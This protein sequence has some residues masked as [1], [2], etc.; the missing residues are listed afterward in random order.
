MWKVVRIVLTLSFTGI[1]WY[2][3]EIPGSSKEW[4]DIFLR[5]H[6]YPVFCFALAGDLLTQV[7]SYL[8]KTYKTGSITK[9]WVKKLLEHI[10][11]ERLGGRNYQTRISLLR[12]QKGYKLWWFYLVKMPVYNKLNGRNLPDWKTFKKNIPSAFKE[13]LY[14]YTRYGHSDDH[15]SFTLFQISDRNELPNGVADK[16][17][18]EQ[19]EQDVQTACVSH[20]HLP[21]SYKEAKTDRKLSSYMRDTYI[22]EEQ[23]HTLLAM[24]TRSNNLYAAPI[25]NESQHIWGVLIIDN[26][27]PQKTSF[28]S[29]L[30]N[31]IGEYQNIFSYTLPLIK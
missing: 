17:F 5:A 11:Q 2:L 7:T 27:S 14:V 19:Q 1:L 21:P 30:E 8:I 15:K 31:Y 18:K 25:F 10:V 20:L 22:Q 29:L 12:P 26:D 13:Y 24:N 4:Y 9:Q 6:K 16:C 28:K 3:Q 23:Y